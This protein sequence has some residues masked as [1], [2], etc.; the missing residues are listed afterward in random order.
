MKLTMPEPTRMYFDGPLRLF[1]TERFLG[2]VPYSGGDLKGYAGLYV[3]SSCQAR[4]PEVIARGREW[5]CK[6]CA[7]SRELER[8]QVLTG[9]PD[10]N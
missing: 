9:V 8:N 6:S 7:Y 5:V 4:T 2:A 3:C 1:S 10:A